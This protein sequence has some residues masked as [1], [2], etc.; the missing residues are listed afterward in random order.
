VTVERIELF[1]ESRDGRTL[2]LAPAVGLFTCAVPRGRVLV[3]GAPAGVLETLGL[4]RE[5]VVPA[6]VSGRVVSDVPERVHAPIGFGTP[7]YELAPLAAEDELDAE[8]GTDAG[9]GGALVYRAPH[10]GRFW[11]RSTPGA[12]PFVRPGDELSVGTTVGMIEVMKT[13]THL[14]Y[15]PR[16]PLPERARLVRTLADDGAEVSDG[17]PLFEIEPL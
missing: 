12:P 2:L 3:A 16:G 13:F 1:A 9:P 8:A 10:G 17:A 6:G 7:L 4:V 15:E 14:H 5:L 11:H